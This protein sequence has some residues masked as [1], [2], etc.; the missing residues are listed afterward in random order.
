RE[1]VNRLEAQLQRPLSPRNRSLTASRLGAAYDKLGEYDAAFAAFITAKEALKTGNSIEGGVG[2]YAVGSVSRIRQHLETLI[3][4]PA[5]SAAAQVQS[6]VFI[7]G[8][9]RSGTTLIDQILSSHPRLLVLEEKESLYDALNDFLLPDTGLD[10]LA[11]LGTAALEDYR[12]KYWQRVDKFMP[13]R[14][15]SHVFV[16]KLP[17]NTIFMPII[18]RL[19]PGARFIFAVRDP[20]DVVLSCFMQAFGL[21]EAMR[22]FLSLADTARYY[23][24]V[25]DIGINSMRRLQR[26]VHLLRYETLV[27]DLENEARRLC[28]FLG[29]EW[30][31]GMLRF[32]DTARKRRINT[33]SYHQVVQ[34]VYQSAR[35][36]WRN[37]ERHLSPVLEQLLPYVEYFDY[38]S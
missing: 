21:N 2:F 33:P 16:D 26:S 27:D 11:T 19:F 18:A 5:V 15:N 32:Q 20:R 6:P 22:H 14:N 28:G 1:A 25:M 12:R 34:P 29:L 23:A 30:E 31:S 3:G 37:Y 7:V 9:P 10:R 24:A 17:L 38:G 35:A 4:E 8:F 13:D 36:R